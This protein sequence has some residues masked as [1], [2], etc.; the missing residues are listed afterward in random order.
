MM[1]EREHALDYILYPQSIAVIG[2]SKDPLKWGHMLLASILNGGFPGKVYPINPREDEIEGLKCYP[3]VRDVPEDVDLAIVVVPARIVAN[4]IGDCVD[5]G[6][7]GAVVIT[8]GFA[9]TGAEGR[10][11]QDEIVN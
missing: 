6:V 5:K 1:K 4:V 7:K 9:E 8:S 3:S 10:K 11:V 2:A